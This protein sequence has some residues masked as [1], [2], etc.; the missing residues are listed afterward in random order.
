MKVSNWNKQQMTSL[1][2]V[3]ALFFNLWAPSYAA[4]ARKPKATAFDVFQL[5]YDQ[6]INLEA[7]EITVSGSG[8]KTPISFGAEKEG[9]SA[10]ILRIM[11]PD[12][13]T[14]IKFFNLNEEFSKKFIPEFLAGQH[15]VKNVIDINGKPV[16]LNEPAEYLKSFD[17]QECTGR[18]FQQAIKDFSLIFPRSPFSFIDMKN[19]E[20]FFNGVPAELRVYREWEPLIGEPEKY[21]M[22]L[23]NEVNDGW[24][25]NFKPQK[26]YADFEKMQTW[27]RTLMGSHGQLFEAPGHQR[28]VMPVIRFK[29]PQKMQEFED[30]AAEVSRVLRTYLVLD[31]IAKKTS[32]VSG[33]YS[34]IWSDATLS[35]F[36]MDTR[37]PLRLEKNRFY[38]NSIGV[39]FRMRMGNEKTRRFTQAIYASRLAT[40]DMADLARL[41]DYNLFEIDSMYSNEIAERFDLSVKVIDKALANSQ[42]TNDVYDRKRVHSSFLMPL[43][44]LGKSSF[45]QRKNRRDPT[46]FSRVYY[47]TCR[48]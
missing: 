35:G 23:T 14:A 6:T 25:V 43:M 21:I 33:K 32:F 48:T 29:N 20:I 34:D 37:G 16:N 40:N 41:S 22:A 46:N 19:R 27:F 17:W 8:N 5:M 18:E 3:L 42:M 7:K 11:S 12:N 24:E 30:K 4:A 44:D 2:V 36:S 31:S 15:R 26:T 28:V 38:P 45:P 39:E 13:R 10:K 1:I 9:S 47:K